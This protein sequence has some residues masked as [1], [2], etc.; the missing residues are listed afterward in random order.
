M[1]WFVDND[2]CAVKVE[3]KKPVKH[4]YT[5]PYLIFFDFDKSN[6]TP[7][8]NKILSTLYKDAKKAVRAWYHITGHADRS[9]TDAYN[10]ALSKRRAEAAKAQLVRMGVPAKNISIDYK[11]EREPLVRTP[12]GVREPQNRR[13]EIR[14]TVE[15]IKK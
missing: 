11:G 7:E 6:I 10:M 14:L 5:R 4:T 2:K 13:D 3:K 1:R 12:D 8:A 15:R 9:G